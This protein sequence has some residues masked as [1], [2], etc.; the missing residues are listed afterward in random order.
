MNF[1]SSLSDF[2]LLFFQLH[3][4]SNFSVFTPFSP[5]SFFKNVC[6]TVKPLR[7]R[8][9]GPMSPVV[10]GQSVTLS[11]IVDGARPPVT[12]S[13]L[14]NSKILSNQPLSSND[15]TSDE[16]YRSVFYSLSPFI[17]S[18]FSLL[19]LPLGTSVFSLSL[20]CPS[21][22][23]QVI[24]A[25]TLH[26]A[27][28]LLFLFLFLSSFFLSLSLPD[29]SFSFTSF[30]NRTSSSLVFTATKFD[31]HKEFSCQ[32]TNQVLQDLNQDPLIETTTI[33]VLCK[34]SCS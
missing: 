7:A 23:P 15:L 18:S 25:S 16:T 8:V 14:N 19:S 30:F 6:Y 12:I 2:I 13:W 29:N 21:G 24:L 33:S 31:H 22:S 4:S 9:H 5:F 28:V 11:C 32:G 3:L 27:L 34:C 20:S 10:A 17:L 1:F 26:S